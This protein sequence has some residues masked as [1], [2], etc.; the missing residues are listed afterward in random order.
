MSDSI[1]KKCLT[2]Y[3]E[4]HIQVRQDFL[5]ICTYDK[6]LY[7]TETRKSGKTKRDE[8]NREC[9]AMILRLL[10]TL[11]DHRKTTFF[12]KNETRIAK[13]LAP[14]REPD[15]YRIELAYSTI[16]K[17]L[18]DTYGEST[19]RNSLAALVQ[20]NYIKRYQKS[21][22]A[23]PEYVL[24][25]AVIQPLLQE[26]AN[27]PPTE[28]EGIEMLHSTPEEVEVSHVTSE[29]VHSTPEMV[30]T[31]PEPLH[32]TPNYIGN[33]ITSKTDDKKASTSPAI[34]SFLLSEDEQRWYTDVLCQSCFVKAPPAITEKLQKQIQKAMKHAPTI[35]L[36][37]SYYELVRVKTGHND[38]YLG[39]LFNDGQE[40]LLNGWLQ[41]QTAESEVDDFLSS[42]GRN[43]SVVISGAMLAAREKRGA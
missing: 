8:P 40:W 42:L 9:M 39:N 26:N 34:P 36:L 41:T 19:V 7:N 32:S 4:R 16:V 11:T 14:M 3:N 27:E 25:I 33:E 31:T 1:A 2:H 6:S 29:G 18:L 12:L 35:E 24:N 30:N 22:N 28:E 13:K 38:I 20:M 23:V 15:E 21:K 43:G 17:L 10:E 37:N 5:E